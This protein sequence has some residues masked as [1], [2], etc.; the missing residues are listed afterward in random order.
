MKIIA[1]ANQKGA[2]E[3]GTQIVIWHSWSIF[4]AHCVQEPQLLNL[5]VQPI[6]VSTR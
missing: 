2:A 5:F 3:T 4:V 1:I 6:F